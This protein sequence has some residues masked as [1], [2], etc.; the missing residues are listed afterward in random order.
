MYISARISRAIF[1]GQVLPRSRIITRHLLRHNT[2][3][4]WGLRAAA[5]TTH[6]SRR[7]IRNFSLPARDI[8]RVLLFLFLSFSLHL[9]MIAPTPK[10]DDTRGSLTRI[11]G[12]ERKLRAQI[13]RL[14]FAPRIIGSL[15][16]ECFPI[17]R[18][19]SSNRFDI[20]EN[21]AKSSANTC[22]KLPTCNCFDQSIAQ[23]NFMYLTIRI[24]DR[25][26]PTFI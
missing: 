25:N 11:L 4:N 22:P 19:W 1:I 13:S 14:W 24:Y 21:W 26:Y 2:Y 18:I 7:F 6:Q 12:T 5:H 3:F 10:Y 16:A 15:I 8:P 9:F 23:V 20:C 17:F